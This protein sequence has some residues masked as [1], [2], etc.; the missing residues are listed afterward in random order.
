MLPQLVHLGSLRFTEHVSA[1][2]VQ[3][4]FKAGL[5]AV[6]HLA[7]RR[8]DNG[9]RLGECFRVEPQLLGDLDEQRIGVDVQRQVT[10]CGAPTDGP[11]HRGALPQLQGGKRLISGA[12]R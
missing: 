3:S 8:L 10:A 12:G 11:Q 7:G 6:E 2:P 4:P 9:G 5:Q 1:V